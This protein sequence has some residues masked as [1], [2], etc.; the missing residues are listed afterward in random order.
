MSTSK[1][2]TTFSGFKEV[3]GKKKQEVPIPPPTD[4][5]GNKLAPMIK[6]AI[7]DVETRDK[8]VAAHVGGNLVLVESEQVTIL[9]EV[10]EG[11]SPVEIT[12]YKD[13]ENIEYN[14]RLA[15][16]FISR[17]LFL[18]VYSLFEL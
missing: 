7:K 15:G 8:A 6:K 17:S 16:V 3:T 18:E 9:C 2:A 12:W 11:R 10:V 13:G 14:D 5:N 1:K 4:E